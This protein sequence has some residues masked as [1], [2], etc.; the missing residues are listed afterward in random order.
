MPRQTPIRK[1]LAAIPL[2]LAMLAAA[3]SALAQTAPQSKAAPD[4]LALLSPGQMTPT[5]QIAAQTSQPAIATSAEFYGYSIDS[6]YSYRQIACPVAPEALLLAYE[7]ISPSGAISRFT[8]VVRR[9]AEE[10]TAGRH[11]VAEIIPI[12][13]FG[14]V[15]FIPAIANP[16]SIDVFN[17]AVS[18][19]PS[20]TQILSAAQSGD[21]PLLVRTLCY[22]AMV[23]EE[24]DALASPSSERATIHAPIPT[25]IF[26]D[27]AKIL[28]QISVRS[29][30][31]SYQVW[32]LTFQSGGKLLAAT[33][34]EHP[35]DRTPVV[36]K[37]AASAPQP[38]SAALA[39]AQPLP[40]ET[41]TVDPAISASP[42][43]ATA[44][45]SA[46]SLVRPSPPMPPGRF[47]PN[48]PQ[49]PSRF[50]P[51]SALQT[52]PHLPQ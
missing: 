18:T 27:K 36:L 42:S 45:P 34:E 32:S 39:V 7:S 29:S 3:S 51:D 8:A 5:D 16:H 12:L 43:P 15:P 48:P 9:R 30:Q 19:A 40:A 26:Q 47:V 44:A 38:P 33:R 24:P 4:S 52:P 50:I 17:A 1:T 25:L 14:I 41:A 10:E 23:G 35:V 22:L 2:S 49:P 28:Q 21:Q 20:A 31:N 6:S 11:A 37:A 46:A 13:R